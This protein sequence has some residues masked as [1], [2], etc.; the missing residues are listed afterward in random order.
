MDLD[1]NVIILATGGSGGH[2]FCAQS[3]AEC[4]SESSSSILVL[5]KKGQNLAQ[6]ISIPT[7]IISS[8]PLSKN[9]FLLLKSL[10]LICVGIVKLLFFF[11]KVKP[12]LI[13]GFG[14]YASFSPLL[15][16]AILRIPIMLYEQNLVIG[17]VNKLFSPFAKKIL[18]SLDK[19][20]SLKINASKLCLVYPAIRSQIYEAYKTKNA[21]VDKNKFNILIIGGSAGA[22]I[23]SS[24]IPNAITNLIKQKINV[25]NLVITHQCPK[26]DVSMLKNFYAASEISAYNVSNFL[27]DIG[28]MYKNADLIIA[29]AGSG[30]ITEIIYMEKASILI[31]FP[32]ATNDHQ[33]KNASYLENLGLCWHI[34]QGINQEEVSD[35]LTDMIKSIIQNPNLIIEK[36]TKLTQYKALKRLDIKNVITQA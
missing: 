35:K 3:V 25:N 4:I 31:P 19:D 23:F 11:I 16:A 28:T 20:P 7:K 18:F 17:R 29:R 36:E 30:T 33:A 1:K 21:N 34:Q 5:D 24:A 10:I 27:H 9:I 12:K 14:S 6:G 22:K 2:V 13:I 32:Y 26:S 15:A 8:I